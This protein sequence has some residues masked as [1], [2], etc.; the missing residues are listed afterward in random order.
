M[1]KN[2]RETPICERGFDSALPAEPLFLKLLLNL[3]LYFLI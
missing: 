1:G 3:E 2:R